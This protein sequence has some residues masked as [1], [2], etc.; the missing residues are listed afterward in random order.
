MHI[1]KTKYKDGS[2]KEKHFFSKYNAERGKW[3]YEDDM[4]ADKRYSN[5]A[6]VEIKTVS[7]ELINVA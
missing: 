6:D 7:D 4:N 5:I 1:V 2:V 3:E